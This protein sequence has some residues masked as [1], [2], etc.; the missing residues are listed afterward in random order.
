MGLPTFWVAF[1]LF[2]SHYCLTKS[3]CIAQLLPFFFITTSTRWGVAAQIKPTYDPL[4]LGLHREDRR[5][6][7]LRLPNLFVCR[8]WQTGLFV[9]C[10]RTSCFDTGPDLCKHFQTDPI[11]P[12]SW[13]KAVDSHKG[14]RAM[15]NNLST[16]GTVTYWKG[17]VYMW[18]LFVVFLLPKLI[19]I[20]V[21]C[22]LTTRSKLNKTNIITGILNSYFVSFI[23]GCFEK[24]E[25]FE[26]WN[27]GRIIQGDSNMT[28]TI[29]V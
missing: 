16:F 7:C 1:K 2:T 29:C 21:C 23:T 15:D 20:Y 25:S 6:S 19:F 27:L 8:N 14:D 4:Q 28:G 9:T 10:S 12:P 26:L 3:N 13:I 24:C 5:T 11:F 22:Y 17:W 18:A